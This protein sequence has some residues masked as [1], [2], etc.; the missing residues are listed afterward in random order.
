MCVNYVSDASLICA[1]KA[2]GEFWLIPDCAVHA[3]QL[4]HN[5]RRSQRSSSVGTRARVWR[6]GGWLFLILFISLYSRNTFI[7]LT[8]AR[9]FTV[10]RQIGYTYNL[11]NYIMATTPCDKNDYL[12]NFYTEGVYKY[13]TLSDNGGSSFTIIF[14]N[15]ITLL[16]I[17][18]H[19]EFHV[20]SVTLQLYNIHGKYKY[21]FHKIK[22]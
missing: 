1:Y 22:L 21:N 13:R 20:F 8:T 14:Y 3:I 9:I 7:N 4:R 19:Y 6:W 2:R 17:I 5:C 11:Y 12:L 15:G 18:F 10:H 16:Y